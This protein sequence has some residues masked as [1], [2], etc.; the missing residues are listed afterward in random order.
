MVPEQLLTLLKICLLI[1]LYLFFFR[2][3]RAVWTQVQPAGSAALMSDSDTTRAGRRRGRSKRA[4]QTPAEPPPVP[5]RLAA[6]TG[7]RIFRSEQGLPKNRQIATSD[8]E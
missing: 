6:T 5:T 3:L 2:V 7:T 1:L 4:G 8:A